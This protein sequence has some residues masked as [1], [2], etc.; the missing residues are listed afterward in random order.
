MSKGSHL[1]ERLL[2]QSPDPVKANILRE[3][4]AGW[5]SPPS[6]HSRSSS[7]NG[8]TSPLR[9]SKRDSPRL[10]PGRRFP[11]DIARRSSNS[12]KHVRNNNLVSK[13]PF[14][15][16]LS[17]SSSPKS[18]GV[19]F[20]SSPR[21]VSG[22]KRQRPQSMHEQAETEN[23]RPFALKRER[24]QS[25]TYQVLSTKEP[26]KNS[27]FRRPGDPPQQPPSSIP[28][29]PLSPNKRAMLASTKEEAASEDNP[30]PRHNPSPIRSS[31]VSKRL[32][33][34]R[35]SGRRERRKTVTFHNTCDVVEFDRDEGEM[36]GDVFE[37]DDESGY[38][39]Y[40]P[41]DDDPFYG[42]GH[43]DEPMNIDEQEHVQPPSA[44]EADASYESINLSDT[45]NTSFTADTSITGLVDEI[46]GESEDGEIANQSTPPRPGH[47]IPTD[48]QTEDGIP[49]GRSHHAERA[50]EFHH[51]EHEQPHPAPPSP[52]QFVPETTFGV[53]PQASSTPP[54]T[55]NLRNAQSPPLGRSTHVERVQAAREEEKE[56][57]RMSEDVSML[58]PSPSPA[59]VG[60]RDLLYGG[61]SDDEAEQPL[62]PPQFLGSRTRD[63]DAD[64]S[65]RSGER[66]FSREEGG[67]FSRFEEEER[68]RSRLQDEPA[69]RDLDNSMDPSNLSIGHSEIS[70]DGLDRELEVDEMG[71]TQ[72]EDRTIVT[73]DR[74][75]TPSRALP[76]QPGPPSSFTD[77]TSS[78]R[79][80]PASFARSPPQ[81]VRAQ[82]ASVES[83]SASAVAP[84]DHL[85]E[86]PSSSQSVLGASP[87]PR[88][89]REDIQ[90]RIMRQLTSPSGSPQGSPAPQFPGSRH[91]S[92]VPELAG[93]RHGSPAPQQGGSWQGSPFPEPPQI[94]GPSPFPET[95][96]SHDNSPLPEQ[97]PSLS[98]P[99]VV[100]EPQQPSTSLGVKEDKERDR[101]SVLTNFSTETSTIETVQK[102]RL[103]VSN[104][105]ILEPPHE[106]E[107]ADEELGMRKKMD[108][109]RQLKLDFGSKFGLGRLQLGDMDMDID[110]DTSS[111]EP[112]R[113]PESMLSSSIRSECDV[114]IH[115]ATRTEVAP[116]DVDMD[117]RSALDRLMEDVGGGLPEDTDADNSM[118]TEET[119]EPHRAMNPPLAHHIERAATESALLGM[120]GAFLSRTASGA[121]TNSLP[122]PPPP[123]DNIRTRERLIIEKRR[124]A[125]RMEQGLDPDEHLDL[126][127]RTHNTGRGSRRR[128]RSTS[129]VLQDVEPLDVPPAVE[130][131]GMLADS[132]ERE[133]KKLEGGSKSKYLIREREGTIYASSS[134]EEKVSHMAGPGDV[135]VGK[136]WRPVRRPSDMNEYAKQIRDLRAQDK[137]GKS[138]GKV[139]VKVIGIKGVHLPLPKE[140]TIMTCTLNNGIHFV[141]TP[142]VEMGRSCSIEQEFE[143]IE[144]S[145]LEFTL[146]L[147]IRRDPHIIAEFKALVPQRPPPPPAAPPVVQQTSSKS[148]MRAF[149]SSSPKKHKE[150]HVSQPAPAPVPQPMPRL[151]E[152]FARYLKPDGTMARAFISFKDI[153]PRCDTRVFE[154]TYPLI[155]QRVELGNKFSNLQ[156]GEIQLKV[157]RLPPM[158]GIPQNQLPQ[159]LE[160]CHR[161][162]RHVNWHKITYFE[163]TLTQNGGDCTS[164]RRRQFRVI[165]GSLVAFNDVTKRAITTIDL[166]KAT[167]VQDDDETRRRALSPTSGV[168]AATARYLD[169]M[170]G[171]CGVERSFRLLFPDNEE[172]LFFADTDEEKAKW[173]DV[174]RAL[175]GHIPP[176]PLWAEVLW[177]RQHEQ[178]KKAAAGSS[179]R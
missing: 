164:W 107:M 142:E 29:P 12:F 105:V 156:V 103:S 159:S 168:S 119:D 92:P 83:P 127:P 155:G 37:S 84:S 32:H 67:S 63:D 74:P 22:E 148:G 42:G 44:H 24:R 68:P 172:I 78:P 124:E 6:V 66:S 174:L 170:D 69:P 91:G 75:T 7:S 57:Q 94:R 16:H 125:R 27:P 79:A 131:D 101:F 53:P 120:D 109:G 128:S 165:G 76:A 169:D 150:K 80:S 45:G 21:R 171:L 38:E 175:V 108:D 146:T 152:N 129:D 43:D 117:M 82:S 88:I 176:H 121:S 143:L 10:D 41:G 2:S 49:F 178:Q 81:H 39:S 153:A 23:E 163:G 65:W 50:G 96:S 98:P 36:G 54:Q 100:E 17:S 48:L 110:V 64:V 28:R 13:S 167:G 138:Y 11:T 102:T 71:A 93:S 61:D 145:K 31:L 70:L 161:G 177:Q 52:P 149:F 34:P 55:P 154:T 89:T 30:P 25:K 14:K 122:P 114:S 18:S 20:P 3:S 151:V 33:G 133:L 99:A 134:G 144:H 5:S 35:V 160:E 97:P 1:K 59:K 118:T 87:R 137:S 166:K 158:P 123:K 19:Q 72:A 136:A 157:F 179:T 86:R 173:L 141:T 162:L 51:Q 111:L 73:E 47:D 9:I 104:A 140:K 56:E 95:P 26:V 58:P 132:I 46:L 113:R 139:F 60:R 85:L 135:N 116:V 15:S 106:E 147:K 8:V 130:N 4:G 40:E 90:R 62:A 77:F 126:P 115:S 112:P